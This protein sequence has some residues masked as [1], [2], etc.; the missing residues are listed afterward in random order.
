MTDTSSSGIRVVPRAS[1]RHIGVSETDRNAA[2]A[3]RK[4]AEKYAKQI[5]AMFKNVNEQN[6]TITIMRIYNLISQYHQSYCA[7]QDFGLNDDFRYTDFYRQLCQTF[8]T[9]HNRPIKTNEPV[10]IEARDEY[11]IQKNLSERLQ[12]ILDISFRRRIVNVS[13]ENFQCFQR[14]LLRSLQS[15]GQKNFSWFQ[16]RWLTNARYGMESDSFIHSESNTDTNITRWI[17]YTKI[18]VCIITL[19]F[20]SRT[21]KESLEQIYINYWN[22]NNHVESLRFPVSDIFDSWGRSYSVRL[23]L[24]QDLDEDRR[25]DLQVRVNKLI[26]LNRRML[27]NNYQQ[28]EDMLQL[29]SLTLM[30]P[31]VVWLLLSSHHFN[32]ILLEPHQKRKLMKMYKPPNPNVRYSV[33]T[34]AEL[35]NFDA[36]LFDND[37]P[38][39]VPSPVSSPVSPPVLNDSP[40][41]PSQRVVSVKP[42]NERESNEAN[43]LAQKL[44]AD[45]RKRLE[46]TNAALLLKAEN[47]KR[48]RENFEKTKQAQEKELL[49]QWGLLRKKESEL[50]EREQQLNAQ[51]A[52]NN[53]TKEERQELRR[54]QHRDSYYRVKARRVANMKQNLRAKIVYDDNDEESE[55]IYPSPPKKKPLNN[56]YVDPTPNERS[57]KIGFKFKGL[58]KSKS[59]TKSKPKTKEVPLNTRSR[60]QPHPILQFPDYFIYD[61]NNGDYKDDD[62]IPF[63]ED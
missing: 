43:V 3:A 41:R 27:G 36:S 48:D 17:A 33:L 29:I 37:V 59:K 13:G 58:L 16:V 60:R 15:M 11:W 44:I 10:I 21:T 23:A 12:H 26:E 9:A 45:E 55:P 25:D 14:A 40:P 53:M 47:L 32:S 31:Y 63:D 54:K 46:E 50:N 28:P 18:P 34:D 51:T 56:I 19:G 20:G 24:R 7:S 5:E 49:N 39:P 22:E 30:N 4:D 52:R 57:S 6:R 35:R 38:S 1:Q 2:N 62:I 42:M 61:A 8:R